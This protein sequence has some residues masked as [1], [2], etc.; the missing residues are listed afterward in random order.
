MAPYGIDLHPAVDK[1]LDKLHRQQPHDAEAI[2]DT[3]DEIAKDPRPHGCKPLKGHRGVL[4]VR[5]GDY[6]ICYRVHDGRL[7]VLVLVI[8]TRDN[9]YELLRRRVRQ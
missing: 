5:V 6:R 9:V 4:R 8:S 7:E 1:F 3:L 2:E